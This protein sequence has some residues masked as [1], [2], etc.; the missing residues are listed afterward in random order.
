[1]KTI[2]LKVIAIVLTALTFVACNKNNDNPEPLEG[3]PEDV[4]IVID[5]NSTF[6]MKNFIASFEQMFMSDMLWA[7]K[8]S[9]EYSDGKALKSIQGYSVYGSF[10]ESL[11]E[12]THE[13]NEKG[14][15][16]SSS[17]TSTMT[18]QNASLVFTYEFDK[19][20]YIIKLTKAVNGNIRDVVNLVYDS[21]KRLIQKNHEANNYSDAY[22][23]VFTYNSD[24]FVDSWT[25][26]NVKLEWI[27]TGDQVTTTN[28]YDQ[29][30]L[31]ETETYTYNPDGNFTRIDYGQNNYQIIEYNGG[32]LIISFYGN[33]LIEEKEEIASGG[34][35][36]RSWGYYYNAEN[37]FLY[38][39]SQEYDENGRTAKKSY[40]EGTAETP[41]LVGYATIDNRDSEKGNKKTLESFYNSSG[42]KLYY[43]EYTVEYNANWGEWVIIAA[44][45]F[46]GA[47]SAITENDIIED[48]VFILI[49][50]YKKSKPE[51][52]LNPFK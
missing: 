36:T 23:E 40:Y 14:V 47:G 27:Y 17:R 12:I 18:M 22:S 21:N 46:T 51:K 9:H 42:T 16:A 2:Q 8:F 7:V 11:F 5:E 44:N 4:D 38:A 13:Y 24:G 31:Y 35:A 26:G 32:G 19:E 37:T 25:Q 50:R 29:G 20:G 30:V 15:I 33:G 6:N 1:M 41:V 10:G 45:W 52:K 3:Q 34:I 48:W 28:V 43:A 39:R 49:N